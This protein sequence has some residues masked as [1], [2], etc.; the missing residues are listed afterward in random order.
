MIDRVKF[1]E[2]L[3]VALKKQGYD[4]TPGNGDIKV[5][6]NGFPVADI[7]NDGEYCVYRNTL[8]DHEYQQICATEFSEVAICVFPRSRERR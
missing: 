4:C 1:I 8:S 7:L 3:Q 2:L 5:S 6:K